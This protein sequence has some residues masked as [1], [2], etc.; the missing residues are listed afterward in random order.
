[1]NIKGLVFI[2]ILCF[3]ILYNNLMR[4]T[5]FG[6]HTLNRQNKIKNMNS[7]IQCTKIN[8]VFKSD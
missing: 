6:S 2:R 8:Q 4:V 1:M 5:H 7:K 3:I